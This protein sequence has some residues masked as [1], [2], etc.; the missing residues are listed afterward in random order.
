MHVNAHRQFLIFLPICVCKKEPA[1]PKENYGYSHNLFMLQLPPSI[2]IRTQP[3]MLIDIF[4]DIPDKLPWQLKCLTV[5]NHG[6]DWLVILPCQPLPLSRRTPIKVVCDNAKTAVLQFRT[7][8]LRELDFYGFATGS[9][10]Y[11]DM[12]GQNYSA[13]HIS[14]A[15]IMSDWYFIWSFRICPRHPRKQG[16]HSDVQ[17]L[18]GSMGR[19]P[20]RGSH[21]P[22]HA[23][24][25]SFCEAS[26][27]YIGSHLMLTGRRALGSFDRRRAPPLT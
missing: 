3:P 13:P 15:S 11:C 23:E 12:Y 18:V 16:I 6:R 2:L 7:G 9:P 24:V 26:S 1:A 19:L 10:P 21:R 27:P 20:V 4:F 5:K 8:F 14:T 17:W 25:S 22:A